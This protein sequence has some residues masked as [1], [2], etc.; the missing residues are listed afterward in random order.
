MK[1]ESGQITVLALLVLAV[2]AMVTVPA[3]LNTRTALMSS[4]TYVGE[5]AERYSADA[6]IEHAS[7]RLKNDSSFRSSVESS[8]QT[9]TVNLNDRTITV[10]VQKPAPPNSKEPRPEGSTGKDMFATTE[11]SPGWIASGGTVSYSVWATPTGT[12]TCRVY[13]VNVLLPPGFAYVAGSSSGFTTSNPTQT[14]NYGGTGRTYLAWAYSAPYPSVGRGEWA[15]QNFQATLTD[16]S[17]DGGIYYT[18][19]WVTFKAVGKPGLPESYNT[20]QAAPV[21]ANIY[22]ANASTGGVAVDSSVA[23]TRTTSVV[24]GAKVITWHTK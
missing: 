10:K 11:R 19:A 12:A 9:Y 14:P 5:A 7:W 2:G 1:K 24:D 3:L 23:L 16:T 18:N 22:S 6:G 4:R 17:A 20:G 8:A 21:W 13:E 15:S